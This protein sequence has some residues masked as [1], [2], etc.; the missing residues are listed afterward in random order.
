MTLHAQ[1][2]HTEKTAK[3]VTCKELAHRENK[4][5]QVTAQKWHIEK[6]RYSKFLIIYRICTQDTNNDYIYRIGTQR[7]LDAPTMTLLEQTMQ[8]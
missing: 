5:Q 3:D 6:P 4:I 8:T 7:K 2:W 1:N